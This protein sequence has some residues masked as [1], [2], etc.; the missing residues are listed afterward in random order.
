MA[1]AYQQWLLLEGFIT[2]TLFDETGNEKVIDEYTF[3]KLQDK[4][5]AEAALKKHWDTFITEQDFADIA[6]A[7]L[8]HVRIPIGYVSTR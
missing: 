2:P 7:G 4:A 1:S 8:N 5:T 6:A 3:T